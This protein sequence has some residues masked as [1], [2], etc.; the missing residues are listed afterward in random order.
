M[1]ETASTFNPATQ[2]APFNLYNSGPYGQPDTVATGGQQTLLLRPEVDPSLKEAWPDQWSDIAFLSS[3]PTSECRTLNPAWGEI[4]PLVA[5]IAV[6]TDT[7]SPG[8]DTPQV[9]PVTDA[10]RLFA[11]LNDVVKY[12]NNGPIGVVIAVVQTLGAATITV[13]PLAGGTLPAVTAGQLLGNAGPMSA[14]GVSDVLTTYEPQIAQYD[15]VL[16]VVGPVAVRWDPMNM[17][18]WEASGTT[19]FIV[20]KNKA[21]YDRFLMGLQQTIWMAQRGVVTLTNGQS[22][23]TTSGFLEQQANAGV[24]NQ[25]CTPAT[26]QAVVDNTIYDTARYADST[27]VMFC[28]DRVWS[29]Y[30]QSVKANLVRYRPE[31]RTWN[32]SFDAFEFP[33][34]R[35]IH[36]STNAWE[37]VGSYGDSM[38]NQAVLMNMKDLSLRHLIGFPM[39]SAKYEL[40]DRSKNPGNLYNF[41]LNYWTGNVAPILKQASYTG[42][43]TVNGL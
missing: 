39:I 13:R 35:I 4:L 11:E 23:R 42:R 9:I 37:D 41:K 18:V 29:A 27:R 33:G 30:G 7:A 25:P 31:D 34:H 24:P 8:A 19:D 6:K 43:F 15:N 14:D 10:T 32:T 1:A 17:K 3:L 5:P 21:A 20:K 22:A 2:Q 36:V 12:P 40:L 26:M 38:Y 28:T 16:Q